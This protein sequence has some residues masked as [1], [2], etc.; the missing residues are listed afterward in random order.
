MPTNTNW[1]PAD[2]LLSFGLRSALG[3]AC[4]GFAYQFLTSNCVLRLTAIAFSLLLGCFPELAFQR[5][6]Q[7]CL[8]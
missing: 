6:R 1:D 8:I 4:S 3:L 5:L 2:F 7:C